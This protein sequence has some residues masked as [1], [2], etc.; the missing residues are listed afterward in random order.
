MFRWENPEKR[1]EVY[2]GIPSLSCE[3]FAPYQIHR[4]RWYPCLPAN[5]L[6]A[7]GVRWTGTTAVRND[8]LFLPCIHP[9]KP[10]DNVQSW[11]RTEAPPDIY[12]YSMYTPSWSWS[13]PTR[14]IGAGVLLCMDMYTER[15]LHILRACGHQRGARTDKHAH[16]LY[17]SI[18]TSP[19]NDRPRVV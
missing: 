4:A 9:M 18:G 6:L 7:S 3:R 8:V 11:Y 10:I 14:A 16:M 19:Q 5:V 12:L 15:I 1:K 17:I 2:T 13:S